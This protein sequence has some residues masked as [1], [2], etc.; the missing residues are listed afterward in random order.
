MDIP[1]TPTIEGHPDETLSKRTSG[2][3]YAGA[4]ACFYAMGF[5]LAIGLLA[6]DRF[7]SAFINCRGWIFG[8]G[9]ASAALAIVLGYAGLSHSRKSLAVYALIVCV[10][11]MLFLVF[12]PFRGDLFAP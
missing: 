9:V 5:P 1:N 6:I 8:G 3:N 2:F 11:E 4:L 10:S 7:N 12:V